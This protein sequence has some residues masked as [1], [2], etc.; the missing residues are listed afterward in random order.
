MKKQTK[1][2]ELKEGQPVWVDDKVYYILRLPN[3]E[4]DFACLPFSYVTSMSDVVF[5]ENPKPLTTQEFLEFM[6][7]ELG[8]EPYLDGDIKKMDGDALFYITKSFSKGKKIW[9]LCY[10]PFVNDEGEPSDGIWET[11]KELQ[12]SIDFLTITKLIVNCLN[13][14]V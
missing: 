8:W 13:L 11:D 10:E 9:Q 3:K 2:V 7:L 14:T 5:V 1:E 4:G 12:E 6:E